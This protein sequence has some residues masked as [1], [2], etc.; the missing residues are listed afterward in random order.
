MRQGQKMSKSRGNSVDPWR[1]IADHGADAV[2]IFLIATSQV[3]VPRRFDE[4]A[5]RDTAE[6]F[7]HTLRNTYDG[8]F[9]TYANFG[10]SPS[11][12]DPAVAE[13]PLLDRWVL[14]RL[15][16]LERQVDDWLE[17]YEP[18]LAVRAIMQFV[19]EDV[20]R[21]FVRLSR[22]RFYEV[23][24][25]DS[26]AAFA[27]LHEVLTVTARLLAPFAPFTTDWLHRQLVGTSVHLAPFVREGAAAALND[28]LEAAMEGIRRLT[29]LGRS[30]R[31][32]A[33]IRIRQPLPRLVCVVPRS[34][35]RADGRPNPELLDTLMPLL[36]SELNVKEIEWQ[37]SG[38]SLVTLT[39][40]ANFRT[41]GKKFGKR[42]PQAAQ[43]V[44][45]FTSDDLR[46]F[47][48]G[49]PLTVQVDD[50]SLPLDPEDLIITHARA[51]DLVVQESDGYLV[52]IDPHITPDLAREGLA[53]E[54]I[55]AIQR[56]RK[57][58]GFAV[59]DRIRV[60]VGGDAAVVDAATVHRT[61]IAGEVL[62]RELSIAES[63]GALGQDTPAGSV[64]GRDPM[65]RAY[66]VV[67]TLE[68]DGHSVRIA[69]TKEVDT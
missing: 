53:R 69:I 8:I 43:A 61:W 13:R 46:R 63:A 11:A 45:S 23:D 25:P 9:A 38:D 48:R 20:S 68:L 40:K 18:T 49:E 41:L 57:E 42:T 22:A 52:A 56:I 55:S 39:A 51:G 12:A 26:R 30:A 47:E 36:R 67:R 28:P 17:H 37:A 4:Q 7:L 35:E 60:V 24:T 50:V 3:W 29:A 19:D 1:V 6:R 34:G 10:W 15:A 64:S 66:D 32:E 62:A 54:L 21:W 2:R 31:E 14:S 33:G 27:T 5:I 44:A 59:S 58:S 65:N 16:R